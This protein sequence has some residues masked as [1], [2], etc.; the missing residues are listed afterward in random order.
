MARKTSRR[1]LSAP[2]WGTDAGVVEAM[3][4][5]LEAVARCAAASGEGSMNC[6]ETTFYQVTAENGGRSAK[7]SGRGAC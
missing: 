3:C 2:W 7:G 1:S 5:L 6:P 4:G